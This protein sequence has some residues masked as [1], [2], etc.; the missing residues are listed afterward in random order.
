MKPCSPEMMAILKSRQFYAADLYTFSGGNMGTTILRYCGG[1][2]SLTANGKLYSAGGET[3]PY[4][5]R[6]STKAKLHWKIGTQVDTLVF[7]V[8]PGTAQI[9]G[10]NFQTAMRYGLFDGAYVLLERA[11]M[12][13]YGDTRAGVIRQFYGRVGAAD[14]GRSVCTFTVNTPLELLNQ[15]VPRNIYQATC[16]NNLGDRACGV[17]I[18]AAPYNTSVGTVQTGTSISSISAS[19]TNLQASGTYDLG[20]IVFLT[21]ALTGLSATIKQMT[22]GTPCTIQLVGYLPAAPFPGDTFQLFWGCDKTLDAQGCPKFN[23]TARYRAEPAV[24]Q[25]SVAL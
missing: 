13:V 14:I 15:Q 11:F 23:N 25:P 20:K 9:F 18:N 17:N 1:D 7:D 6:Q 3:G 24:P 5:D 2:T 22:N 10:V 8:L 21:G 16:R 4:F 19:V 12:L